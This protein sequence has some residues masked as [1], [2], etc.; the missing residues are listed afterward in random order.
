M[1]I[2]PDVTLVFLVRKNNN[3]ISEI[4]LALKK[5]GFGM[6]KWNGVGG[7]LKENE[8]IEDGAR[9]ET[10]EEVDVEILSFDKVA[11]NEFYFPNNPEWSQRVHVFI[12][13]NWIDEIKESEEM[14][15]KWFNVE[16]IPYDKMWLD[17][18]YWIPKI[19]DGKKIEGRFVFENQNE[20][21]GKEVKLL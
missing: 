15:P 13:D 4:C 9:R 12:C 7:K 17:D 18:Q 1:K 2:L 10:K 3:K 21:I 20:I 19:L 5:R 11:I 6:G 8:S 16:N 14:L